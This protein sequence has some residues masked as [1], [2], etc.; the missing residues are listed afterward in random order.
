MKT[1]SIP[2]VLT[3]VMDDES[4]ARLDL[5]RKLYFP[6]ERNVLKAHLTIYHQLPGQN[7]SRIDEILRDI[8][9]LRLS[10]FPIAFEELKTRQGF[11]GVKV[12]SPEL[13]QV[14]SELDHAFDPFL[15]AQDRK[16]YSPHV[17]VTNLG[18]P[19]DAQ[20]VMEL[21]TKEFVPWRGSVRAVSLFH[22]RG[23]PWEE[24]R[25]YSFDA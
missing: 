2:L 4:Q 11:V 13:M 15:K 10:P 23:G 3:F 14:K 18:S 9:H 12:A 16:P 1:V 19:K 6:P 24:Y 25:T 22:Y 17:T 21:L 5:W 20:K 7:I 8:S